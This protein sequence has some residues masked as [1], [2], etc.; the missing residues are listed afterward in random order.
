MKIIRVLSM[1]A[2]CGFAVGCVSPNMRLSEPDCTVVQPCPDKALVYFLRTNPLGY[3]V[4]AAVYD[5]DQFI[6]VMP[7]NQ[8]LP[9]FAQPGEHLFMVISEAADFLKADLSP[10]KTY[11][12]DV[13]P[14]MGAWRARFSL[15]P[16]TPEKLQMPRVKAAVEKAHL[17]KNKPQAQQWAEST[18]ASVANKKA[19]YLPKWEAKPAEARPA[20]KATDGL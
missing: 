17:I 7:F 12:I 6:G 20:L 8:K 2:L 9:Y 5:G 14:R 13:L 15:A 16:L 18:K 3:A 11:Y 19:A 1:L 10:G 4:N